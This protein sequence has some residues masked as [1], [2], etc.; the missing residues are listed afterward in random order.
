MSQ[1]EDDPATAAP[2]P[3][4]PILTGAGLDANAPTMQPDPD[5]VRGTDADPQRHPDTDT[6]DDSA[7]TEPKAATKTAQSARTTKAK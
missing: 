4:H 1:L 2:Q 3:G 6:A 5:N 7:D